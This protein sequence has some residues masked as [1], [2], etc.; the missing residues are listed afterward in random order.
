MYFYLFSET[1]SLIKGEGWVLRVFYSSVIP[2]LRQF[3]GRL[4]WA[5]LHTGGANPELLQ[6]PVLLLQRNHS[7]EC[8]D[9]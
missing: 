2:A 6:P 4:L 1:Q 3:W 9:H 8:D 5:A 7:L